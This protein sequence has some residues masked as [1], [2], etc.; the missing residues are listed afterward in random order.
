LLL[1]VVNLLGKAVEIIFGKER[2][3]QKIVDA[4]NATVTLSLSL[5]VNDCLLGWGLFGAQLRRDVLEFKPLR[6]GV[7]LTP[8]RRDPNGESSALCVAVFFNHP[9]T[10]PLAI[11]EQVG[12]GLFWH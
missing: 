4:V 6:D 10:L 5:V 2:V 3:L 9:H 11:S 8:Q 12:R 1:L 7:S